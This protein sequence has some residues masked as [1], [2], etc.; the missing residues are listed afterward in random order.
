VIFGSTHFLGL[1]MGDRSIVCAELLVKGEQRVVK[2]TATMTFPP[3]LS[4]DSPAAVGTALT[5]FLRQNGF[6]ASR[7]VIGLPAKW[8]VAVEK[9]VPPAD[10]TQVH[11]LLRLQAERLSIAESGEPVFDYAGKLDAGTAGKVL[12]VAMLR[13]QLD[14][15]EAIADAAGLTVIAIAPASLVLARVL[16]QGAGQV[17][18]S[19]PMILLGKHG[20]EVVWRRQGVAQMLRHVS[21][22]TAPGAEGPGLAMLGPELRRVVVMGPV[23]ELNG[24]GT[25]NRTG[26]SEV[27]LWDGVGLSPQQLGELSARLGLK[28]RAGDGLKR[29]NLRSEL[30]SSGASAEAQSEMLSRFAPAMALALAGARRELLPLDLAYSKLAPPKVRK[31]G[32]RSVW[33][34]ALVVV[35]LLGIGALYYDVRQEQSH[36]DELKD[37]L[38]ALT[39]RIDTAKTLLGHVTYAE[40]YFD[41]RPPILECLRSLTE[42]F[43]DGEPIWVTNFSLN[44]KGKGQLRGKAADQPTVG[45]FL[46][47]LRLNKK[48]S[49]VKLQDARDSGSRAHDVTFAITFSYP[50]VPDAEQFQI[51]TASTSTAG[52]SSS[53]D[54]SLN[55]SRRRRN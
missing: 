21:V 52:S 48:F 45:L 2:Q 40:V 26:S 34:A 1:L 51:P 33:A 25:V 12:L 19:G 37:Q 15:V 22:A 35:A 8:L 44:D 23:S 3:E 24:N 42:T 11:A 50:I 53:S 7:A 18:G 32:R 13:K 29:L 54:A 20:A 10:K 14:R 30:P 39:P 28:V 38:K 43:R 55:S 31:F 9:E 17:A 46:D 47:R 41:K 6:S 36:L 16:D 5:A 27:E 49:D 4:M